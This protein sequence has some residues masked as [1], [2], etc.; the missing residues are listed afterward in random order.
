MSSLPAFFLVF[1]EGKVGFFGYI[2]FLFLGKMEATVTVEVAIL[3]KYSLYL[4]KKKYVGI[5]EITELLSF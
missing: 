1:K 4:K 2:Y 5:R 3:L